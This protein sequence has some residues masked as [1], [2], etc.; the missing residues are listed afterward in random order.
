MAPQEKGKEPMFSI[1]E[2]DALTVLVV[3]DDDALRRMCCA[4]LSENGFRVLEADNGL[5]ALFIATERKGAIDLVIT[6]LD[7]PEISG[8]E[9]GRALERVWPDVNVLYMSGSPKGVAAEGLPAD[10]AFLAKP[11]S[12]NRLLNAVERSIQTFIKAGCERNAYRRS[13]PGSGTGGRKAALHGR[14]GSWGA[15]TAGLGLHAI[16]V[17][18]SERP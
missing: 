8:A 2:S 6:D 17:L 12:F 1:T 5:E 15:R 16:R 7:M 4:V 18:A 10:C 3:D 14:N 9:L 13:A 11:F